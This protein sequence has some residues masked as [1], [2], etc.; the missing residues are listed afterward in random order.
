MTIISLII[1]ISSEFHSFQVRKPM[2]ELRDTLMDGFSIGD[3][4]GSVVPPSLSL[5]LSSSIKISLGS[6]LLQQ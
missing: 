5:S 3:M 1:D 2:T 6:L 4:G